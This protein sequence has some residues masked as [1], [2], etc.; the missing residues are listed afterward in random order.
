M[1]RRERNRE[2]RKIKPWTARDTPSF[3]VSVILVGL[4][5]TEDNEGVIPNG[6]VREADTNI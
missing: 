3:S 4:T 6:P 5:I 2:K 1:I